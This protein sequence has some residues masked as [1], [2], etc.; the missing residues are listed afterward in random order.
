MKRGRRPLSSYPLEYQAR[1]KARRQRKKA[2]WM[3]N[4]R[5]GKKL[6]AEG[7]LGLVVQKVQNVEKEK[8]NKHGFTS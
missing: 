7:E 4:Y 1:A 2:E 6:A 5:L 8:E 3:R